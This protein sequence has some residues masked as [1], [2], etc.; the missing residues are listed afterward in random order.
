VNPRR[1]IPA[2]CA[3]L[4]AVPAALVFPASTRADTAACGVVPYAYAGWESR[5]SAFGAAAIVTSLEA[6]TVASGHVA[7]W[8]GVGG[9]GQG[10]D[11]SDEWIQA[12]VSSFAS[13]G[14]GSIYYEVARPNAAPQYVEVAQGVEVGASHRIAVLEMAHRR[15]WWRVWIDGRPASP[16]IELP[17]S[18]GTW[19]PQAVAESWNGGMQSCN[20]YAFRFERILTAGGPGGRWQ[21]FRSGVRISDAGY[22]VLSSRPASFIATAI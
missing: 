2:L 5:T 11:G 14:T 22:R 8:V 20:R 7:A 16:P 19:A 1:V 3:A 4:L 6:P 15:S 17:G 18:H 10:P 12:G 21:P 13:P 9:V